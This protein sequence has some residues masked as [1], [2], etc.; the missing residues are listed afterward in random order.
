MLFNI[1]NFFREVTNIFKNQERTFKVN[2][3][4]VIF[5]HF[6]IYLV[7]PLQSIYVIGRGLSPSQLGWVTGV[8]GILGGTFSFLAAKKI[9]TTFSLKNY[10]LITTLCIGLGSII[11]AI[12][13]GPIMAALGIGTFM[14]SWYAMMHLCPAVCG[15]CLSNDIRVTAMQTCDMLAST[16]KIF[17]PA[18]GSALVIA[19]GGKQDITKGISFLYYIAA[20]G[21]CLTFIIVWRW[22]SDP[23]YLLKT[24]EINDERKDVRSPGSSISD[25]LK[26]KKGINIKLLLITLALIQVPWFISNIYVPLFAQQAKGASTLTIGLM[27]SSFWACTLLLAIP[28]GR[29]SDRIGRKSSITIFLLISI[30]SFILLIV[31]Q[32]QLLLLTSGFFQ[33][34]LFFSLVTSG[35][36]SAEA[37]GKMSIVEWMGFLGF[38]KGLMAQVGPVISGILWGIFG[39]Y[40][41]I[42]L[43]IGC[44]LVAIFLLRM[45]PETQK[46]SISHEVSATNDQITN[47][48]IITEHV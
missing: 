9:R 24:K 36:M 43:L 37:V 25:L 5:V 13:N 21:F 14:L 27:Q 16:P 22:F 11:L 17:A 3:I 44:Q 33:G 23:S 40:S 47:K 34:F 1:I 20:V 12:A 38:L 35:G 31:A 10:F 48:E 19:F 28:A 41:A 7:L 4:R 30:T 32:S 6:F 46:I 29:L 42:Y 26:P 15:L 39:P 2:V 45:L 8:A 18:I